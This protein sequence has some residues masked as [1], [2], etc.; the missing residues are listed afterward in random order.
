MRR[1]VELEVSKHATQLEPIVV[2]Q[3]R[4]AVVARYMA[5][6]PSAAR[7]VAAVVM[8][9]PGVVLTFYLETVDLSRA[10]LEA[11]GRPLFNSVVLK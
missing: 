6:E 4:G 5:S 8:G 11:L 3:D 1:Q 2:A 9:R 7:H 10:D